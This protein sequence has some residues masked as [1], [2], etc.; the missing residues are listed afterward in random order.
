MSS[1]TQAW[2]TTIE[3]TGVKIIFF[4]FPTTLRTIDSLPDNLKIALQQALKVRFFT[5]NIS[6]RPRP[7]KAVITVL[8]LQLSGIDAVNTGV[9]T[10]KCASFTVGYQYL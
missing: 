7:N 6:A 8:C 4:V 9:L 10:D 5:A 2:K 3:I 1:L